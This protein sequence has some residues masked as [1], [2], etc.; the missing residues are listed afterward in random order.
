MTTLY[1]DFLGPEKY[2][3]YFLAMACSYESEKIK[4]SRRKIDRQGR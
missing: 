1:T 4:R 3:M 2:P